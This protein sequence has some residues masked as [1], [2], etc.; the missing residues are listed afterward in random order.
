MI[1]ILGVKR[2]LVLLVLVVLNGLFATGVYLYLMPQK[3][4]KERDLSGV[5]GQIGTLQGDIDRLQIEF[6]QLEAQQAQFDIL[7]ERGFFSSQGRRQ[8]EK[9]LENIQKQAGVISAVAS[10]KSGTV[11]DSEEA[12]KAAHKILVSPI[13]IQVE[14]LDDVDVFRYLFLLEK[15]FPGHLTITNINVE[16]TSDISGPVLRSIA[17]GSNPA[18]VTA[19]IEMLWR[20]MI[21]ESE[22]MNTD[23]GVGVPQ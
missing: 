16:R 12:Q 17:S 3:L 9:T 22:V 20:T 13:S 2:I 15:F 8:A 21:P 23:A 11:E 6:D 1:R 18:L 4:Q 19:S 14:A 5:R 10:I 7:N